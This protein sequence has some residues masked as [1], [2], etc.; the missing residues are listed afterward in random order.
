MIILLTSWSGFSQIDTIKPVDTTKVVLSYRVAKL[1]AKDLIAG[2]SCKKEVELLNLKTLMMLE[3]EKQ[4]DTTILLLRNKNQNYETIL[5]KKD[6][7][8]NQ[9]DEL[10]E[11]L[12][13]DLKIATRRKS[14]YK[15]VAVVGVI[16]TILLVLTK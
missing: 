9:Y 2:D 7:Q 13:R 4:K 16:S 6:E 14:I 15:G 3:R 11:N 10:T 5:L 1:V 12:N 8:I